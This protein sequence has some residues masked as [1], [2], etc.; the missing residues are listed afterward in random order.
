MIAED[1]DG[2]NH[3]LGATDCGDVFVFSREPSG[4]R[5][6]AVARSAANPASGAAGR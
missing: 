6:N 3:L 5:W 1:G 4:T 2:T